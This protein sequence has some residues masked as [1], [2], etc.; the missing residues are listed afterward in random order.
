MKKETKNR[1]ETL[2]EGLDDSLIKTDPET[3]VVNSICFTRNTSFR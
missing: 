2:F 3:D 1:I